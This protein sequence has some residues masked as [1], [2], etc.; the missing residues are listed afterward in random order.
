MLTITLKVHMHKGVQGKPAILIMTEFSLLREVS[1][2]PE[3]FRSG[4]ATPQPH[5]SHTTATPQPHHSHTTA[6]PQPH[7]SHTTATP[8]PHQSQLLRLFQRLEG[9][10]TACSPRVLAIMRIAGLL[11]LEAVTALALV[12]RWGFVRRA[13]WDAVAD[14]RRLRRHILAERRRIQ[15]GR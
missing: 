5:H 8:K 3:R 2:T 13:Y 15:I 4:E 10:E 12:R 6:T 11:F 9:A 1:R 7:H 14:C